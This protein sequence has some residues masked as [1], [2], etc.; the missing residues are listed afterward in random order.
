MKYNANNYLIAT[1][2]FFTIF[3]LQT[4]LFLDF[5]NVKFRQQKHLDTKLTSK[6]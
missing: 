1:L 4:T 5:Q 6:K 2:Q 3:T